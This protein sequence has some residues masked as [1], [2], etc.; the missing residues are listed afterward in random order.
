MS[1]LQN[2]SQKKQRTR[3]RVQDKRVQINRIRAAS[4]Q[5]RDQT[6]GPEVF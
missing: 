4:R 1:E 3:V 2:I 6:Y 5:G